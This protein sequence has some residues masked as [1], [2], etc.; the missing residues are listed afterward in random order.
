MYL[1]TRIL[2]LLMLN[3]STHLGHIHDTCIKSAESSKDKG[4]ILQKTSFSK[5]ACITTEKKKSNPLTLHTI[6]LKEF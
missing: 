3:Y 1:L 2:L 6:T 4:N 5:L